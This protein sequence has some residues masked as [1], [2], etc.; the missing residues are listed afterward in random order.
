MTLGDNCRDYRLFSMELGK[1]GLIDL[2]RTKGYWGNI[3]VNDVYLNVLYQIYKPEMKFL[4]LGCGA[5]NVLRFASNI[6]YDVTGVEFN[7]ELT[8]HITS[9]KVI[10]E[11]ITKLDLEF[12]KDFDVVY[13]YRP[14]KDNLNSYLKTVSDNMKLDS[15]LVTP[16]FKI[17]NE[18]LKHI[19]VHMH[20]IIK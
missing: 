15:Y 2:D 14:L 7:P 6:G 19:D 12:Y 3:L 10:T 20:Q 13:A 9:H 18:K 8:K 17:E 1:Q 4:D 16:D 5:G 11:D